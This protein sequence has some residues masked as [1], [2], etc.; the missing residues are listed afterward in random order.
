MGIILNKGGKLFIHCSAGIHRTGMITFALLLY[1]G[2]KVSVASGLLK[3][4]REI[5]A[6]EVTERR[7][8]WGKQFLVKYTQMFQVCLFF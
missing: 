6:S 4:M 3:Q 7:L 8:E 2:Y 5:A 1:L